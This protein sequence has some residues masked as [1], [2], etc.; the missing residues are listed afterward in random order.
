MA[1]YYQTC[2]IPKPEPR[3]RTKARKDRED[4]TKLAEFCD[5]VWAREQ[6]KYF[7][8]DCQIG[9]RCNV[10]RCQH[11]DAVVVR[12]P[13]SVTGDVHHR[14]GRRSKATRYDPLNGVLLCNHRVND[15]HRR[16]QEGLITV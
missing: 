13:E 8:A 2:A 14:I 3:K 5:G 16:A 12:S 1:D 9:P 11:C 10:A 4:A 7:R 6:A 15:C